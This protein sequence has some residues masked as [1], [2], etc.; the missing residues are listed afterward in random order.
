MTRDEAVKAL[1]AQPFDTD[2]QV[3]VGGFLID[4]TQID[5]D[6]PRHSIVLELCSEDAEQAMR[7]FLRAGPCRYG[8][9]KSL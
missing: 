5:F 7:Y 2:V 1:E 6:E 8:I 4:V 3:N 9:G